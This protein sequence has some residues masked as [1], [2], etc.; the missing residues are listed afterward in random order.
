[1]FQSLGRDSGRSDHFGLCDGRLIQ[2]FNRS[3]AIRVGLTNFPQFL[4]IH[5]TGFN[6]SVAIR[7]GLT[8]VNAFLPSRTDEVSIA[9][10][11]FGSV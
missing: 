10:S 5:T 8:Q 9:R 3:V 4:T 1:M 11:R 6:R 2:S 7:V